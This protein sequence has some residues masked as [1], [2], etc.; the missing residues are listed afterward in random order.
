MA[1]AARPSIHPRDQRFRARAFTRS[2]EVDQL[3]DRAELQG[4]LGRLLS[5]VHCEDA[6]PALQAAVLAHGIADSQTRWLAFR[7]RAVRRR[8]LIGPGMSQAEI[9]R[10]LG[11]TRQAIQKMLAC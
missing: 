8:Q 4:A 11:V 9:A 1:T 2:V 6:D 5:Y 7:K 3:R 10:E